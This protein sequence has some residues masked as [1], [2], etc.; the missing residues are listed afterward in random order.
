M[1]RMFGFAGFVGRVRYSVRV[2]VLVS[3]GVSSGDG[4][5]GVFTV[6]V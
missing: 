6:A 1:T 2:T 5:T 3:P 4:V